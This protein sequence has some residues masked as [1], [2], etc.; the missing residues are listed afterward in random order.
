MPLRVLIVP[1]KFKGT[2]PAGAAAQAIARGW[3]RARPRDEL[4]LLPMS[5]GGDGFGE[6]MSRLLGACPRTLPAVDAAHRPCAVQW[7]WEPRTRTAIVESAK[8][9]GLAML[10]WRQFHPFALDTAGLGAVIAALGA[11]GARRCLVGLGGSATNDGGFGLARALSWQFL[12]GGG[13]L[14]EQWTGLDKLARIRAPRR[15]RWFADLAAAVDVD[16]RLLGSRGATRVYGPQKGL[17]AGDFAR[18][19][20]C[21]RTL[22][23]VAGQELGCDLSRAPGAGAAGGLGFGL[24]AFLGA[25]VEPGFDLFARHAALERRLRQTDLV[26]TGEGR[27]DPSSLMGKGVGRLARHC[28]RLH[29]PC[30]ALA[31]IVRADATPARAFAQARALTELA[32]LAQAKADPARWL[33]RLAERVARGVGQLAIGIAIPAR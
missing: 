25:R 30:I 31:G 1:D 13:R 26:V 5:D 15:R 3:R 17:R 10:P 7:W 18:A 29:I 2:L 4:E 27:L 14:I 22:A 12:D 8:V 32:S 21:L 24:R 6:V 20:R 33:E 28:R 23:R 19:E 11:A 16:N 9:V